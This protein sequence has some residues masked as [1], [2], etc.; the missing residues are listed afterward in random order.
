MWPTG[1]DPRSPAVNPH[2]T[3]TSKSKIS[4]PNHP[5]PAL[6]P[7]DTVGSPPKV[8][9]LFLTTPWPHRMYLC[10]LT[11]LLGHLSNDKAS[12]LTALRTRSLQEDRA[13]CLSSIYITPFLVNIMLVLKKV[14][15][16]LIKWVLPQ[17]IL[18]FKETR[19]ILQFLYYT[20]ILACI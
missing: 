4:L 19:L 5:P 14:M 3:R 7:Q 17:S 2:N 8:K 9:S 11:Q 13:P 6:N 16:E 18:S 10:P 1:W 15:N 12:G 20:L